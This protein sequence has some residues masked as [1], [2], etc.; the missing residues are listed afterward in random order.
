MIS[1]DI[2]HIDLS[3]L[4]DLSNSARLWI[5]QAERR[6][7]V[8]EIGMIND[9]LTRFLPQWT[10]HNRS[11]IARHQIACDLFLIIALDEER[12]ADASGCSID[13]MTH[14]VQALSRHLDVNL[15]DRTTFYFLLNA[16]VLGI[17]MHELSQ[18]AEDKKINHNT[19]V[20]NNLIKTKGELSGNW[21]I[22]VGESWHS[23]FL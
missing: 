22:P 3:A 23:R 7:S 11:L 12:S 20:F 16:E 4:D 8:E 18:V 9:H 2:K 1:E 21:V 10:S 6:L 19:L 13:N 5:F 17:P 14:Q 15:M